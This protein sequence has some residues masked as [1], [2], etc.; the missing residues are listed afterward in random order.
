[1]S[2]VS[3]GIELL[4]EHTSGPT[5]RRPVIVRTVR[6]LNDAAK[7]QLAPATTTRSLEAGNA[8]K[9]SDALIR[10]SHESADRGRA[11]SRPT[12][13]ARTGRP[14]PRKLSRYERAPSTGPTVLRVR[15]L[16]LPT[17]EG[18]SYAMTARVTIREQPRRRTAAECRLVRLLAKRQVYALAS[19]AWLLTH[20][21]LPIALRLTA[22][23]EQVAVV[24]VDRDDAAPV[25]LRP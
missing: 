25:A 11:R 15:A 3:Y 2:F 19:D 13:D 20:A 9:F 16:A 1:M 21:M 23:N 4:F 22:H 18:R 24:E 10:R 7:L 5:L 12:R 17:L 14:G 8:F 6:A